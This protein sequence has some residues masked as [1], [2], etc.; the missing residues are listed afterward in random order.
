MNN[1]NKTKFH[2]RRTEE[3]IQYGEC[4]LSFSPASFFVPSASKES[5]SQNY[6]FFCIRVLNLIAQI[7]GITQAGGVQDQVAE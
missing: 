3:Q 4:L 5:K 2:A 1:N 6:Y 7:K